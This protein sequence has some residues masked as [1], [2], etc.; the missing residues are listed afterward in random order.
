MNDISFYN[1][2]YN[3]LESLLTKNGNV[4]SAILRRD[5]FK[6]LNIYQE[7]I[8][9][10]K[11]FNI[12]DGFSF[13]DRILVLLN[14]INIKKCKTCGQS[15]VYID[16]SQHMY[17]LCNHKFNVNHY[18][19]SNALKNSYDSRKEKLTSSLKN[20]SLILSN[21]EF[22][23]KLKDIDN[24]KTNYS[25]SLSEDNLGFFND[26]ILK[27][28]KILPLDINDLKISERIYILKNNLSSIPKCLYCDKETYFNNRIIGFSKTC[29]EHRCKLGV[30]TRIDNNK[31][32][33][34]SNFNFKKYEI[35]KYPEILTRDDLIIKCKKCGCISEWRIKDGKISTLKEKIL[36][37]HCENPQSKSEESLFEFL[38]YIYSGE[39]IHHSESRKIISP[40][41]LDFY[42]PEKKIAIEFDGIF[43]H[44]E[45]NGGKDKNY[46][47]KKTEMCEKKGIQLIHIFENEWVR[48][49]DIVKSRI[50]NLLGVYDKTIYARKCL[51]KEITNSEAKI[52]LED[53]HLQGS[54]N[55]LVNLGLF[56]NNELVSLMT[57]RK[58][59]MTEKYEWEL[60]RFCNRIEHHIIGGASKLLK[61]FERNYS[62]KSLISYADRRWSIGTLYRKLGF[63]L[64]HISKPNYWYFKTNNRLLLE[65]RMKY[66]KS[67]QK[68]LIDNF[69]SQ[70]TEVVNM[71]NNGFDRIFD[72]GNLVFVKKY[73]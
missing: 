21:E 6:E 35:V 73:N 62:P 28:E 68:N 10:T 32:L 41:E 14:N 29:K 63:I 55:S 61:H 17:R 1:H 7:I 9:K 36:C 11:D 46:H 56:F 70:A 22:D 72:C 64:D 19:N 27:T 15:Y 67:K 65:N 49:N 47:L 8:E 58:P 50:K 38:R 44:S 42:I 59:R 26:V 2:K 33:I 37:R 16:K 20:H 39:I 71:R 57:F 25:F 18:V 12:F 23:K 66:Q 54:V 53:N 3:N 31:E 45:L 40:Y 5:W 51:I 4:N 30:E 60:M 34:D 52:F 43:W 69:D 24:L 48:K 13:T